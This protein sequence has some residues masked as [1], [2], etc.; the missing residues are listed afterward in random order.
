ML[1]KFD[2]A[3]GSLYFSN[4]LNDKVKR[5]KGNKHLMV[6]IDLSDRPNPVLLFPNPLWICPLDP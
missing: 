6:L 4:I 5:T 3:C 1:A 2:L